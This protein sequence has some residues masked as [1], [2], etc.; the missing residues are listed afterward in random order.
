MFRK[1][2]RAK[3]GASLEDLKAH[4]FKVCYPS[5]LKISYK[6]YNDLMPQVQ[7]IPSLY[8]DFFHSAKT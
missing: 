3:C 8:H 2:D 1:V 5:K 6:K 4:A 7:C